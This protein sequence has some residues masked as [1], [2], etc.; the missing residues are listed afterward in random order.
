[1][2]LQACKRAA[3]T[4][5]HCAPYVYVQ[6]MNIHRMQASLVRAG[7]LAPFRFTRRQVGEL[8]IK[9]KIAYCGICHSDL[10]QLHNDWRNTKFPLVPGCV[11]ILDI[12]VC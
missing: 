8:D 12:T 10:H 9:I 5:F 7:H 4:F 2:L 11:I 6:V 1:M 3:C